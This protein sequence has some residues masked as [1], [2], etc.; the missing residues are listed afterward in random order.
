MCVIPSLSSPP[1]PPHLKTV[2]GLGDKFV[3]VHIR[4]AHSKNGELVISSFHRG[5]NTYDCPGV[6]VWDLRLR[7]EDPALKANLPREFLS[8]KTG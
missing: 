4:E 6:A 5:L 3:V 7:Q 1:I 2:Y 8:L